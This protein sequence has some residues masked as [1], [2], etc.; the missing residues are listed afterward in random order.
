M[1]P[2]QR[3]LLLWV[4]VGAVIGLVPAL[5][6]HLG[7]SVLGRWAGDMCDGG[8]RLSACPLRIVN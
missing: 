2:K 6:E 8:S 5:L 3:W 4:T 7:G 1:E